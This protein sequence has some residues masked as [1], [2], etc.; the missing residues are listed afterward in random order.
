[1]SNS[2][3]TEMTKP[4][5]YLSFYFTLDSPSSVLRIDCFQADPNDLD[6]NYEPLGSDFPL[7]QKLSQPKKIGYNSMR[8]RCTRFFHR[9]LNAI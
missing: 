4:T 5:A 7:A 1:M 2:S 3:D 6:Q 9:I 8:N